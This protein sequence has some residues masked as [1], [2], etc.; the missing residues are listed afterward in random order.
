MSISYVGARTVPLAAIMLAVAVGCTD[1]VTAPEV[2]R[3]F[4]PAPT[5]PESLIAA[6]EVIYNDRTHRADERLAAY[7]G[8]LDSAFVYMAP[9]YDG[10]D[11]FLVW[12][13]TE[14]MAA[15]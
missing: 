4:P 6:I 3:S 14:E 13:L 7:A 9:I 12:Y 5:A 10:S 8:V 2:A 15:H 1:K 11:P